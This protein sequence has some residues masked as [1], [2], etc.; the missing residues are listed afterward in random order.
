M[1]ISDWSSDVCSS[2]L[3]ARLA[4]GS[5]YA[6]GMGELSETILVR[7]TIFLLLERYFVMVV[8]SFAYAGQKDPMRTRDHHQWPVIRRVFRQQD[9]RSEEHTSELQ[10]LMRS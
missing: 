1:R 7:H 8:R 9:G 2:D 3:R 10:S 6:V 5:H 4:D